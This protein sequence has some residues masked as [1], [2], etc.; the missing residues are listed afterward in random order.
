MKKKCKTNFKFKTFGHLRPR[1]S[2]SSENF[3]SSFLFVF[4]VFKMSSID[5]V[6]IIVA[7]DSGKAL[8]VSKFSYKYLI[9]T[10]LIE[11]NQQIKF[12]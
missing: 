4:S 5:K 2:T 10:R 7:G 3:L 11:N 8:N 9:V 12:C 1:K 6:R